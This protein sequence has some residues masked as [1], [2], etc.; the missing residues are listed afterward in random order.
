MVYINKEWEAEEIDMK[1]KDYGC[2]VMGL[3]ICHRTKDKQY[4][5]MVIY[6]NPGRNKR[7]FIT[8]IEEMIKINEKQSSVIYIGDY[9]IDINN[10]DEI[11]NEMNDKFAEAGFTQIVR[12]ITREGGVSKSTIDLCHIDE[13]KRIIETGIIQTKI[14][15]HWPIYIKIREEKKMEI[16]REE[17]TIKIVNYKEIEREIKENNWDK[18]T[19][20]K[21]EINEKFI[22]FEKEIKKIIERNTREKQ[23][24]N[25]YSKPEKAWITEAMVR[26]IRKRDKMARKV[27]QDKKK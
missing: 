2:E 1:E 23:K 3:K 14:T 10:S 4:I 27:R 7:K 6:R 11:A 9:N 12:E 26:A 8:G 15:D 18:I 22:K 25:H 21:I 24:T 20:E 17:E 16:K 13:V 5:L 19:E